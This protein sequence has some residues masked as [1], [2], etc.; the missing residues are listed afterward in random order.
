[1]GTFI[2]PHPPVY[3][4]YLSATAIPLNLSWCLHNVI[5]WLKIKPFLSR[6]WSL[7]FIGTVALAFPYWIVEIY[8]NF[9]YFNGINEI[10]A[11]TRPWEALFRDPWWVFTTAFLFYQILTNYRLPITTVV[12]ISPRFGVLLCAMLLSIIFII[13]DIL[14]VTHVF[15]SELPDGLNPFWKLATVFKCLTDSIVLDDFKTALDRLMRHKCR[16]EGIGRTTIE[17]FATSSSEP[18]PAKVGRDAYSGWGFFDKERAQEDPLGEDSMERR[19]TN[20]TDATEKHIYPH[21]SHSKSQKSSPITLEEEIA[22]F[23]SPKPT[24]AR[25]IQPVSGHFTHSD[26]VPLAEMLREGPPG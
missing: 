6:K 10:F 19:M 7:L 24:Y 20:D 2:F 8:A 17:T 5:S 14:S 16:R 4:W 13:L 1:M 9:T 21:S 18:S 26:D 12:W 25:R 11:K 23:P 22:T 15:D 3:G